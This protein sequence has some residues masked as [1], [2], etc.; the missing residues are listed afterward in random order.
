MLV[1]CPECGKIISS[2]ANPCP[3]CGCPNAGSHSPELN[4]PPTDKEIK[5]AKE[6]CEKREKAKAESAAKWTA[7]EKR[8][9]MEEGYEAGFVIIGVV[10]FIIGLVVY[11]T[12]QQNQQKD[13]S[14]SKNIYCP[15]CGVESEIHCSNCKRKFTM[16]GFGCP[17]CGLANGFDPKTT[18]KVICTRCGKPIRKA[19]KEM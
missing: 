14:S 18:T 5:A 15:Y 6:A 10:I 12:N 3:G 13:T 4:P 8:K 17:Y 7:E 11:F 9:K 2:E 1:T 16:M 19:I